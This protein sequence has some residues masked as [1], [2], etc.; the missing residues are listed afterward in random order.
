MLDFS[1]V[2]Q[3]FLRLV[4]DEILGARYTYPMHLRLVS[5]EILGAR[6]TYPMHESFMNSKTY[7]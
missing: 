6:Y 5:D 1:I 2:E 3:S 7:Y 4:S